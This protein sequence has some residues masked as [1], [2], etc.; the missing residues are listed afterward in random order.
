[1]KI[2]KENLKELNM[3]GKT[4]ICLGGIYKET[5]EVLEVV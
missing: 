3:N 5:W 2:T 4:E 1:M